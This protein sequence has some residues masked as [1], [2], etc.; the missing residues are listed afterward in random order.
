MC[1]CPFHRLCKYRAC[2]IFSSP[3]PAIA[4]MIGR[5]YWAIDREEDTCTFLTCLF[6]IV[7]RKEAATVL[8]YFPDCSFVAFVS[9]LFVLRS[10]L[11]RVSVGFSKRK[12]GTDKWATR[13]VAVAFSHDY[14]IYSV[15]L[16]PYNF[17]YANNCSACARAAFSI[18]YKYVLRHVLRI[19]VR[20]YAIPIW[21]VIHLAAN[22]TTHL[23]ARIQIR[24]VKHAH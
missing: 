7:I 8:A 12:D 19:D 22:S 20:I 16:T 3:L 9:E 5:S 1:L 15:C 23:F 10:I 13:K 24:T 2:D 21:S 6:K 17:C 14:K 18:P 4:A 11:P